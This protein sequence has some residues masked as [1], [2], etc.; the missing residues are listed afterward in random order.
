[1]KQIFWSRSRFVGRQIRPTK[2]SPRVSSDEFVVRRMTRNFFWSIACVALGTLPLQAQ[3][4]FRLAP[5]VLRYES[6]FFE[7]TATVTMQFAQAGT[8]IRYTTNGQDPSERDPVYTQPVV[9][10]KNRTTLKA[11]VF[12]SG[13]LPSEVVKTTFFKSGL[14]IKTTL[15][16]LPHERYSGSG[17]ATLSDGKGGSTA[18][19]SP[20]WLG[21]QQD[22]VVL[23]LTLEKP[24]RVKS[25]FLHVLQNHGA[26]IFLP[27]AVEFWGQKSG[28]EEWVL[29]GRQTLKP[30]PNNNRAECRAISVDTHS[31]LKPAQIRVKIYPLERI[32]EG[33]PGAGQLA[34]IFL[35]EVKLY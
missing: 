24:Q 5:P 17:S 20:T 21:F 4:E 35:D 12:G 13:Y 19:S 10:K 25:L 34:W 31:K 7:K 8:S 11:R 6:V 22:S 1:M 28:S 27:Q 9:L 2:F 33:H 29:M 32:P 15:H 3:A 23:L 16:S 18:H 14:P 26:W 30:L